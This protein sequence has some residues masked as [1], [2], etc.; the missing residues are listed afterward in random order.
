MRYKFSSIYFIICASDYIYQY[1]Q[2][3][4]FNLMESHILPGCQQTINV[5]SIHKVSIDVRL[6][7]K[8]IFLER[9][10]LESKVSNLDFD[11]KLFSILVFDK[12][13]LMCQPMYSFFPYSNYHI[14]LLLYFSSLSTQLDSI[15]VG[16]SL[17]NLC[18]FSYFLS[19]GIFTRLSINVY[20]KKG[21]EKQESLFNIYVVQL[22]HRQN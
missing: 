2:G 14:L 4:F 5:I 17:R 10:L 11:S 19:P 15:D 13:E 22:F 6:V 20:G 9:H 1:H 3:N 18:S 7:L 21:E 16:L 12:E 8:Q